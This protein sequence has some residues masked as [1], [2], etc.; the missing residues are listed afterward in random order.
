VRLARGSRL[1]PYEVLSTL[2]SGGMAEVYRARDTRLGRDIA[3]KVVNEALAGDPELVRRFEQEA[4]LAG[5]LNHPN[6]VALYDFGI[7]EGAPYFITELLKGESLRQRLSR[8]R[9]PLDT[10]LEWGSQLAQGLAAAHAEGIV[11]RDVKPE[12]V[13]VTSDG[14][15]KLLD[16]GIAKLAE[17]SRAEGP[18]G[19]LDETVTP[20]SDETR[21]GAIIGTP[22][23]MSPEQVR[24]EKVDARTDIFSLGAVLHEMLS[25]HRLFPGGS[26]LETGHAILHD[27]PAHLED[28]PPAVDRLIRRCLAK[29]PAARLQS[30]R[31]LAF[32]LEMLRGEEIPRGSPVKGSRLVRR[33]WW[34]L[35]L[36]AGAGMGSALTWLRAPSAPRP[37]TIERATLR[38]IPSRP[39]RFTP[40]GRIVFTAKFTGRNAVFERQLSSSSIQPL[41]LENCEL[42][43]VSPTGEFAVLVGGGPLVFPMPRSLARAAAGGDPQIVAENVVSADWSPAGALAIVRRK[44]ERSVVEYPIGKPVFEVAQPAWIGE[45][46]VSPRGNLLGFVRHPN[47]SA[48]GEAVVIDLG[49]KSLRVSRTWHRTIGVAW[50]SAD[51]LWYTAGEDLPRQI[52]AMPLRGPERTVYQ[53]LNATSLQ[54]IAPD[55]RVLVHQG[56]LERDIIFLGERAANVPRSLSWFERD[57]KARLSPDGRLMLF[58]GWDAR[59]QRIAMLRKTSGEL[60]RML[61]Q[62]WPMD[63]SSDG[64]TLLLTSENGEVLTVAATEGESRSVVPLQGFEFDETRFAGGR[65]RAVSVARGPSDKGYRL[66]SVELRTGA[67]APLSEEGIDED[68]LE[69]SPGARWAATRISSDATPAILSLSGG[70]LLPISGLGPGLRPAGWA[71]D[72][73]LWLASVEEPD[74]STFRLLRYDVERR[75]TLETRIVGSGGSER[76]SFVQVTPNG[77]NIVF[78][79]ERAAGHL[80]VIDG[81]TEHR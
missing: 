44:G 43:S 46:R 69:V 30:A 35:V 11:H 56:L 26:L 15:V 67:A 52:Q 77:R 54:D 47:G 13:F 24:G 62:G 45:L 21:T 17:A 48:S 72:A 6:L 57:G 33:W 19:L 39:A 53:G 29:D 73:E 9:I 65:D 51:E 71:N 2:G 18:H 27:E 7:H 36:L 12:N 64:R 61:G 50:A 63:L 40:D 70:T 5:S 37:L 81:L 80:Y 23:Y 75:R 28:V 68:S 58:S 74:P 55:G 76:A 25:G 20:A 8:G 41:G 78:M 38:P 32:A 22:A 10:A 59:T 49:G 1:G 60:P 4:R 3:L 42:Q 34:A 66:Y 31:D 79:R 16:F 14:H